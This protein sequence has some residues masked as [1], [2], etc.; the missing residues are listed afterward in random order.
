MNWKLVGIVGAL[1][2]LVTLFAVFLSLWLVERNKTKSNGEVKDVEVSEEVK[3]GSTTQLRSSTI[4]GE[5]HMSEEDI[6]PTW[7]SDVNHYIVPRTVTGKIASLSL[8]VEPDMPDIEPELFE[9]G[10]TTAAT[11]KDETIFLD[12]L[13]TYD[14]S[15]TTPTWIDFDLSRTTEI[16]NPV[17]PRTI[18]EA[19]VRRMVMMCAYL[20]LSFTYA[21]HNYTLRVVLHD[22]DTAKRGDKLL[23]RRESGDFQ[24]LDIPSQSFTS[25]RPDHPQV[26]PGIRDFK[27]LD[28]NDTLFY[29]IHVP[30]IH[31]VDLKGVN[32][33]TGVK[34]SVDLHIGKYLIL[35]G[36]RDQPQTLSDGDLIT[37]LSLSPVP[38]D[39]G[40]NARDVNGNG[41]PPRLDL[42]PFDVHL[43]PIDAGGFP[44]LPPGFQVN[45]AGVLVGSD[46]QTVSFVPLINDQ[47][48]PGILQ[49]DT[50]QTAAKTAGRGS[51]SPRSPKSVLENAMI[52]TQSIATQ[53]INA[54]GTLVN[55]FG[56]PIP[57]D[58][59]PFR[60]K[61]GFAAN[62]GVR[63]PSPPGDSILNDATRWEVDSN[64]DI[65]E[66]D[67]GFI[68]DGI[69][70]GP[71]PYIRLPV[72]ADA[73]CAQCAPNP[74]KYLPGLTADVTLA[75]A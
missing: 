67:L 19:R 21:D 15:L 44:I 23:R 50:T 34:T 18:T 40:E 39:L 29:P 9:K 7:P 60:P 25:T 63:P 53:A 74:F 16:V 49:I 12:I 32:E 24:W 64:D 14:P 13:G 75:L 35:V 45:T 10:V 3:D 38:F 48:Y 27:L 55:V 33:T 6:R 31:R 61:E 66:A 43:L 4:T 52:A 56:A 46:L 37:L 58:G 17:M 8:V 54:D 42:L 70:V 30:L 28:V 5:V 20:D 62:G 26:I 1:V 73:A 57:F 68:G 71:F 51:D 69:V 72:P 47:V 41:R 59:E 65:S 2:A 11:K 22:I 36:Q